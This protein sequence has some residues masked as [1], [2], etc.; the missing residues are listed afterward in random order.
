MR[1]EV[2]DPVLL[3]RTAGLCWRS[4]PRLSPSHPLGQQNLP[5]LRT[6]HIAA[7]CAAR[8][9]QQVQRPHCRVAI[10]DGARSSRHGSIIGLPGGV[11]RSE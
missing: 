3:L 8:A 9:G 11:D 7:D 4:R 5:H 1:I 6:A 2:H 10:P